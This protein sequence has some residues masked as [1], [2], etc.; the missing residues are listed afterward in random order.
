[1]K[2]AL[3]S[4]AAVLLIGVLAACNQNENTVEDQ[5]DTV[6]PVETVEAIEGDLVIEKSLYGR[7]APIRVTP[8]MVQMPGEIDE[9]K[10]SNGDQVEEDDLIATIKTQAG[11]QNIEAPRKGEITQL[12]VE[13]GDLVTDAEPL[14]MIIDLEEIKV[15]FTVTSKL[16]SLLEKDATLDVFINDKKYSA[17]VTSIGTLPDETGLYP[18]VASVENK[19]NEILPGMVAIMHVPEERIDNAI[20]LPTEAIIE[21]SEGAFVY[22]VQDDQVV[23]TEITILETQS[24]ETAIEGE[25]NAGDQVVINGQLTLEDGSKVNVVKEGNES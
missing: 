7:T 13:E 1:M 16:H 9:L 23:K 14:A 12:E 15:N 5:E 24:D 20:I 17:D 2:K 3:L 11:Q 21:E 25:V 8:I 22:L 6:I 4:I 19:A 10:V 18:V